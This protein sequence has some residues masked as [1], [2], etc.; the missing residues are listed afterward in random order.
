MVISNKNVDFI[1]C[2]ESSYVQNKK[3]LETAKIGKWNNYF[4]LDNFCNTVSGMLSSNVPT[5]FLTFCN[6]IFCS[7]IVSEELHTPAI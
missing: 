7:G 1:F 5:Y 6:S 2:T 3:F 4:S